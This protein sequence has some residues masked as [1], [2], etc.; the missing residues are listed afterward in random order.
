[1]TQFRDRRRSIADEPDDV[2][3]RRR[4]IALLGPDSEWPDVGLALELGVEHLGGLTPDEA[5]L[6]RVAFARCCEDGAPDLLGHLR[7]GAIR[8]LSRA[9]TPDDVETLLEATRTYLV[10]E[11]VDVAAEMRGLALL[12]LA[13]IDPDLAR[14]TAARLLFDGDT[15]GQEPHLTAVRLLS[16]NNDHPLLLRWLDDEEGVRPSEAAAEAEGALGRVLPAELWKERSLTRLGDARPLETLSAVE[17]IA[18]CPRVEL[19]DAVGAMLLGMRDADVFRAAAL[20]FAASR[21]AVFQDVI[22]SLVD[23]VPVPLL[24][25]Y[26]DAVSV[27]RD[28]RRVDVIGRISARARGGFGT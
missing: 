20:A 15:P 24:D 14:W 4:I 9:P 12:G 18:D 23:H 27:S 7:T 3:R 21:E 5:I 6:V 19:A 22:L 25:A 17:A 26:T 13:R 28:P 1:M 16:A 8:L 10:R 11:R 2:E